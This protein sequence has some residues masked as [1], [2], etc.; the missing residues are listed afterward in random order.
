MHTNISEDPKLSPRTIK[1]FSLVFVNLFYNIKNTSEEKKFFLS[2]LWDFQWQQN[3]ARNFI[4]LIESSL[5]HWR[6]YLSLKSNEKLKY[7][8]WQNT[9]KHTVDV[10]CGVKKKHEDWWLEQINIHEQ[11]VCLTINIFS[12]LSTDSVVSWLKYLMDGN[13]RKKDWIR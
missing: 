10:R 3:E 4:L 11:S 8:E 12:F 13:I 9:N 7:I 6:R 5:N 1:P 2:S